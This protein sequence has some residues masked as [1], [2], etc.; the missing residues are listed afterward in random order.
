[1]QANDDEE[2]L[3]EDY[4]A[5]DQWY[6]EDTKGS[7][8][9]DSSFDFVESPKDSPTVNKVEEPAEAKDSD[10]KMED[11][12]NYK[13]LKMAMEQKQ[14][15]LDLVFMNA[16]KDRS[17]AMTEEY[18]LDQDDQRSKVIE[19]DKLEDSS[20]GNLSSIVE[21]ESPNKAGDQ[22]SIQNVNTVLEV[23]GKSGRRK[24]SEVF[25]IKSN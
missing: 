4:D 22:R 7:S 23:C 5:T 19:L 8:S 17:R 25:S 21:T 1:M 12:L 3:W 18:K 24:I 13:T 20:E 9:K 10:P 15:T 14:K 6:K 16:T 11:D 2:E